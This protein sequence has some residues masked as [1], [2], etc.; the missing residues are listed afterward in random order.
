MNT[1]IIEGRIIKIIEDETPPLVVLEMENG[2]VQTFS[3]DDIIGMRLAGE[4]PP[5]KPEKIN[6]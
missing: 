3:L 6:W 2:D 5:E 4:K 1:K